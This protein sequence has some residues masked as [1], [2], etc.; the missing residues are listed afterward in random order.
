MVTKKQIEKAYSFFENALERYK[1]NSTKKN[2][3]PIIEGSVR[4]YAKN[5][6][7][8]ELYFD[9]NENVAN[10]LFRHGHFL[11]DLE[12]SVAKLKGMKDDKNIE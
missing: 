9:L 12:G 8:K 6:L 10:G 2:Q 4:D 11:S 5:N 3:K 1:S 7:P